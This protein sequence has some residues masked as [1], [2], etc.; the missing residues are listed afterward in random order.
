MALTNTL[1]QR[2]AELYRIDC[3]LAHLTQPVSRVDTDSAT[4]EAIAPS[5]CLPPPLAKA[6]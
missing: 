2:I 6:L 4:L 1:F 5:P 3:Q